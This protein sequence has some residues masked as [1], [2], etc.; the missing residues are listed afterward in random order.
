MIS[1]YSVVLSLLLFSKLSSHLVTTALSAA[2]EDD[3][4]RQSFIRDEDVR[5]KIIISAR[6]LKGHSVRGLK[7]TFIWGLPLLADRSSSHTPAEYSLKMNRRHTD[8]DML[9]CMIGRVYRPCWE[10]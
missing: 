7:P 5:T 1:V 2:K 3:V 4:F 9:R 6:K 10:A 8:L